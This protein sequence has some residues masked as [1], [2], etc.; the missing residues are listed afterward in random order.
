VQ[1]VPVLSMVARG[2]EEEGQSCPVAGIYLGRRQAQGLGV[3]TYID[4][5]CAYQHTRAQYGLYV[6]GDPVCPSQ[7]DQTH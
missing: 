4:R 1:P 2:V 7:T 5:G 6:Y 3:L